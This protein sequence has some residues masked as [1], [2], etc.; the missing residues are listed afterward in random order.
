MVFLQTVCG[1][2]VDDL[3][4]GIQEAAFRQVSPPPTKSCCSVNGTAKQPHDGPMMTGDWRGLIIL[5]A[6]VDSCLC[7]PS[8]SRFLH[9]THIV[10]GYYVLEEQVLISIASAA[11][12]KIQIEYNWLNGMQQYSAMCACYLNYEKLENY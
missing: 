8:A 3:C 6:I 7:A 1:G 4:G 9:I 12:N 10:N 2:L 5:S 11:W